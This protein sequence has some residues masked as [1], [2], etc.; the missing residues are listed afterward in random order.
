ME[1]KR[2]KNR[3]EERKTVKER[4]KEWN[5]EKKRKKERKNEGKKK[6]LL[7]FCCVHQNPHSALVA[8]LNEE[9]Q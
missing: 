8:S 4:K 1:S 3:Q 5:K 6:K 9:C 7:S 2:K